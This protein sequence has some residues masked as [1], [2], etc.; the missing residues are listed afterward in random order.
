LGVQKTVVVVPH[1]EY[2]Q[3]SE[4]ELNDLV[5]RSSTHLPPVNALESQRAVVNRLLRHWTVGVNSFLF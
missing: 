5:G 4:K 1:S 3:E 2:W